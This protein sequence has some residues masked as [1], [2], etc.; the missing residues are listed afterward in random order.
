[1]QHGRRDRV[2]NLLPRASATVL[3]DLTQE[4]RQVCPS[5]VVQMK[6]V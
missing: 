4:F 5:I 2:A 3:D 1:M 6:L